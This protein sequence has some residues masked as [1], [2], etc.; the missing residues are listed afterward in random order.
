MKLR[1]FLLII[2]FASVVLAITPVSWADS[3][4]PPRTYITTS[5]GGQ[6]YFKMIPDDFDWD[7]GTGFCFKVTGGETDELLWKLNGWYSFKNFLSYDGKYL[8][9]M[10]NWTRGA[11]LSDDHLA[12]AFYKEGQLLKSYSTKDLVKDSSKIE[13]TISHY[14]WLKQPPQL[15]AFGHMF[16]L[17]TIDDIEYTFNVSTGEV[18]SQ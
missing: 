5:A 7:K 12:V 3:E 9:R 2:I 4:A 11:E 10:G 16:K 15:D 18:V 6:Y 8:V 1:T 17:I 13:L 14:F